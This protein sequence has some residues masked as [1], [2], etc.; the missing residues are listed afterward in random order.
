MEW[1]HFQQNYYTIIACEERRQTQNIYCVRWSICWRI[2]FLKIECAY[3]NPN[4]LFYLLFFLFLHD[5]SWN[6]SFSMCHQQQQ[7]FAAVCWNKGF[8]VALYKLPVSIRIIVP[9]NQTQLFHW[10][11]IHF[12]D[13]KLN[14]VFD[15]VRIASQV[16]WASTEYDNNCEST[17]N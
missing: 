11:C 6:A 5:F 7:P 15:Y 13:S 8:W 9:I 17:Y 12:K 3:A 2:L 14:L 1:I 16:S 10:F 4:N